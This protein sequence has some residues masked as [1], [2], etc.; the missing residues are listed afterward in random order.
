MGNSS[1]PINMLSVLKRANVVGIVLF[2]SFLAVAGLLYLVMGL[3]GWDNAGLRA[4]AAMFLS[5]LLLGGLM[6][7]AWLL[8]RSSETQRLTVEEQEEGA[9]GTE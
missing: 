4:L 3:I 7:G 2:F 9:D 8:W 5:P 6:L 1:S